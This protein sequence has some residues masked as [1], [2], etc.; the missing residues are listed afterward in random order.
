MRKKYPYLLDSYA[1]NSNEQLVKRNFLQNIENFVNQRQYVKITLLDWEERPIKD[2]EGTLTGG[3]LS[4]DGSSPIRCTGS[5]TCS[6]SYGEYDIQLAESDFAINKKI[7]VEIG[8]KNDSNQYPEYPILWFPQGVFF[9]S[10]FSCNSAANGAVNLSIG[11][12]DKMAGLNGDIGGTLPALTVLDEVI[13]QLPTGEETTQKIPIYS[14]IQENVNHFGNEPLA[15]IVIEDVPARIRMVMRWMGENPIYLTQTGENYYGEV[16]D[17][18]S[19]SGSGT[20]GIC[21]QYQLQKPD[22]DYLTFNAGDDVGYIM[23]DFVMPNELTVNAG[24]TVTNILDEIVS[25]L[26]NYEYFY[27]NMGVFHFREIKNYVNTTQGKLVLKESSQNQ[28][29]VETNNSKSEYLFTDTGNITS[30][31]VTPNYDNIKNDYVIL[32]LSQSAVNDTGY[33]IRYHLAIDDKPRPDYVDDKGNPCYG[34]YGQK[35]DDEEILVFYSEKEG[36]SYTS[37]VIGSFAQMGGA[38]SFANFPTVGNVNAIYYDKQQN[39]A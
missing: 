18:I 9:I 39:K 32:G 1:Y 7:F 6:V 37:T 13:T 31:N 33:E 38:V 25:T 3:S 19:E 21:Y 27:D 35:Q 15:N 10:S 5:F 28:Y 4:K 11:L 23:S 22:G 36:G 34:I 26:G 20:S 14:I 12:K 17:D 2:L 24:S 16:V 8:I 29:L 30:I